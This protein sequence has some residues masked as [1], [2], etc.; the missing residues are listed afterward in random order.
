MCSAKFLLQ[1]DQGSKNAQ[2]QS[3]CW[4]TVER[5]QCIYSC[6][7]AGDL[8]S[9]RHKLTNSGEKSFSWEQ[10]EFSYTTGSNLKTLTK[11][12]TGKKSLRC[13]QC[14][15][16]YT[17]AGDLKKHML[18]QSEE[19][20]SNC[21]KCNYSCTTAGSL[22]MHSGKTFSAA[23]SVIVQPPQLVASRDTC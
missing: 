11:T 16:S 4:F 19:N 3:M 13:T 9:K 5:G 10:C 7:Q 6:T 2:L 18:T 14:N 12:H 15:Y 21:T 8:K 22:K 20:L 1:D 17:Q 23:H